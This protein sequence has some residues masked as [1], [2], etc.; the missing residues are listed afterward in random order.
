MKILVTGSSGYLGSSFIKQYQTI[1]QFE[2]F[3]LLNQKIEDICF[4]NIELILHC[5]ALVHQTK[6]HSYEKYYEV[7]VE[8]PVK[9]AKVAKQNGVKQFVFISTIAVY[10]DDKERVDEQISCDPVT[11]Y[12]KSKLEAEKELLELNDN[13]FTVSIIRSPL[14]YG[15]NAPGNMQKL[16]NIVKKISFLPFG[17]IEN[18][19]S[20]V[21]IQ[22]I[23][24]IIDEVIK[25]R[26]EGIFLAS[27]N[28]ALSTT[29]LIELIAKSLEKKVS[30]VKIPFFETVLQKVMPSLYKRLYTSLEV[31]GSLTMQRLFGEGKPSL[32]CTI[33]EGI[34]LMCQGVKE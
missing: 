22:N 24:H 19:R 14:I 15:K 4:E 25:Q 16:V 5:A 17:G 32:P 12:G 30:F 20:F 1:Y 33:E 6:K 23:C 10:G 13:A 28:K 34:H 18:K 26:K 11:F 9:L 7:N 29:K 27:D 21:F 8:Y 2:K 31:D 3:S